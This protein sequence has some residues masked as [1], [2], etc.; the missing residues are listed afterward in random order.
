MSVLPNGAVLE[1]EVSRAIVAGRV[2]LAADHGTRSRADV[3]EAIRRRL[4]A[5]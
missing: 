2:K 5:T 4:F 3:R 1:N